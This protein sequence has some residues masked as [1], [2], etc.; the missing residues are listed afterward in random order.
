[1]SALS[2]LTDPSVAV[3]FET[4]P[5]GLG[6]LRVTDALY[7]G[8]PKTASPI[9]FGAQA[10]RSSALYRFASV[11]RSTRTVLEML[12]LPPLDRPVA[13]IGRQVLRHQTKEVY[14]ALKRILNERFTVPQTVL[15]VATHAI[16]AHPLGAIKERL[17]RELGIKVFLVVQVTDDSPQ[18]IWYVPG[19]DMIFV[20]SAYTKEKLKSYA[21]KARLPYVRIVVTPYPISPLLTEEMTEHM[22][23]QRKAQL[24]PHTESTTHVAVPIS[25]AAVG[26]EYAEAFIQSLHQEDDRFRF[27][28]V[29][30]EAEFTQLFIQRMR[31]L[32]YIELL[33]SMHERTTIDNYEKLY[34]EHTIALEVTKPSEQTFK[35]LA[36]PKHRGGVVMLFTAPVGGQEYD[37]VRFLHTHGLI[38]TEHENKQLWQKAQSGEGLEN[39]DLLH[40]AE[41]WRG[42][43]LPDK[44]DAAAK[45]T[46][47]CL[48]HKLFSHMLRY[49]QEVKNE[50]VQ[51]D[52]VEQFWNHVAA[53]V[54][55]GSEKNV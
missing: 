41:H 53:L 1:M 3:I 9:L 15:L 18:A 55:Q 42:I 22:I 12:Q 34:K 49:S 5:L 33:T 51:S 47:W 20:P 8:L 25:G 44:P 40:K 32:P 36:H 39:G 29:A 38:P 45:F 2:V 24:N 28:I 30:R 10:P 7:H 13:F 16:H 14:D 43:L 48:K 54:A 4:S 37:N 52:G 27:H 23:S 19:A 17:M 35:V 31:D 46:Q 50:E 11:H 21:M 6:H 26:T